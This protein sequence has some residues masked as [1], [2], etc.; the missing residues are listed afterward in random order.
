MASAFSAMAVTLLCCA[1]A[2]PMLGPLN[3][4]PHSFNDLRQWHQVLSKAEASSQAIASIGGNAR[5][6]GIL[7]MLKLDPQYLTADACA[8]YPQAA[9]LDPRGCL[10][11]NHDDI[12]PGSSARTSFNSSLD[13]LNILNS[14]ALDRWTRGGDANATLA[15]SLCFKGCGGT[16]CPCAGGT[17]TA[18]W[19]SLVDDL[20]AEVNA[21]VA[22]RQLT[23][24]TMILDGAGNPASSTG[25]LAQRWRPWESLFISGDV[26]D[27]A[28]NSSNSTLGFDRL[29]IL[30]E[31][32]G[33]SYSIAAAA[34]FGKFAGSGTDGT[35]GHPY[36]IWEP[37]DAPK[38]AAAATEY[39]KSPG[40]PNPA[41][42]RYAINIDPAQLD[43]YAAAAIRSGEINASSGGWWDA[44]ARD[45]GAPSVVLLPQSLSADR[46]PLLVSTWVQRGGSGVGYAVSLLAAPGS[47]LIP[48]GSGS[49]GLTSYVADVLFHSLS[50]LVLSN[51]TSLLVLTT[52]VA[53]TLPNGTIVG[54]VREQVFTLSLA[55]SNVTLFSFTGSAPAP[56]GAPVLIA[57]LTAP[58]AAIVTACGPGAA[59]GGSPDDIASACR[60]WAWVPPA[61]EACL[62]RAAVFGAPQ[63]SPFSLPPAYACIATLPAP[64]SPLLG[65]LTGASVDG[66]ALSGAPYALGG[67]I[68]SRLGVGLA[69]SAG[70]WVFG[71]AVCVLDASS[72]GWAGVN[73]PACWAGG[74]LTP[75]GS[76]FAPLL[77]HVGAQPSISLVS[78]PL[79]A[80]P[81]GGVSLL[82]L[83]AHSSA[84]C[85]NS[86]V[87]NKRADV[88]VCDGVPVYG[89]STPYLAYNYGSVGAWGAQ[90]LRT[91]GLALPLDTFDARD[92]RG[93]APVLPSPWPGASACDTHVAH[94]SVGQGRR[95]NVALF[96]LPAAAS[97]TAT[98][99]KETAPLAVD[100]GGRLGDG[101]GSEDGNRGAIRGDGGGTGEGRG[102]GA[103]P[104]AFGVV[105][106]FEGVEGAGATLP[107]PL[108]CGAPGPLPVGSGTIVLTGWRLAGGAYSGGEGA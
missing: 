64:P 45:G 92:D 16:G 40:A 49:L 84:S 83:E 72:G 62:V 7:L 41:G 30:N 86:E 17:A 35:G 91:A 78:Y 23:S 102:A 47:P 46:R 76:T 75:T 100:G 12:K 44:A 33:A 22:S 32:Q 34:G 106:L 15:I 26:P 4:Q 66:I 18:N 96:A 69:F 67:S 79:S 85:P 93:A 24:L 3:S 29:T 20:F 70:G 68:D 10:L 31:P 53:S 6:G 42:L 50:P 43:V 1:A 58:M 74:P 108:R 59:S 71:A 27:A 56:V 77:S 13:F 103:S 57:S 2:T 25:C 39:A 21:L 101:K 5:G 63:A 107:D 94:G 55:D 87:Q 81:E 52:G 61:E 48:A 105:M 19:L 9:P 80:S 51:G 97:A 38:I 89:S 104:P 11:F 82:V 73:N 54:V 98:A 60:V 65:N 90:L 95:P 88:G 28:F 14:T 36:I 8:R 37:S 99:L